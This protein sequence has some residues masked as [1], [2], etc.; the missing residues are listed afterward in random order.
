MTSSPVSDQSTPRH[1]VRQRHSTASTMSSPNMSPIKPL[2]TVQETPTSARRRYLSRQSLSPMDCSS[3]VLESSGIDIKGDILPD[4]S[5]IKAIGQAGKSVN[6]RLC[7]GNI[8]RVSFKLTKKKMSGV[9]V[10][11][12]T[13]RVTDVRVLDSIF[14]WKSFECVL[15]SQQSL[16]LVYHTTLVYFNR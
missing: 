3:G 10:R 7:T 5:P 2:P 16:L 1:A 11:Q 6:G 4:L 15:T 9:W 14:P 12:Q 13:F 8:N